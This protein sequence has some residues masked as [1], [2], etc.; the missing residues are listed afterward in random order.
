MKTLID[1]GS[2]LDIEILFFGEGAE[3]SSLKKYSKGMDNIHFFG[4]YDYNNLPE[5]YASA[6]LIWAAYPVKDHNVKYA[7]SNKFFESMVLLKPAIFSQGS[8][9]GEF[10]GERKIGLVIDPYDIKTAKGVIDQY[11]K[12]SR[13]AINIQK[14]MFRSG[15]RSFWEDEESKLQQLFTWNKPDT[16]NA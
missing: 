9:L 4:K 14:N 16:I 5:I 12:N 6:D 13:V 11:I 3:E 10:V 7:I 8:K 15:E 2:E 1:I